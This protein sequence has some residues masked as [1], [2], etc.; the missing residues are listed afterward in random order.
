[1]LLVYSIPLL[2]E[3]EEAIEHPENDTQIEITVKSD[4]ETW[5]TISGPTSSPPRKL[6][7]KTYNL[8]PGK[9]KI[10]GRKKGHDVEGVVV[11]VEEGLEYPPIE[12]ICKR[13][14]QKKKVDWN[15]TTVIKGVKP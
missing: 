12:L 2:A 14:G 9:Y 6:I 1:M 15:K 4:K 8:R 11:I 10:M 3:K 7:E 13:R 5:I